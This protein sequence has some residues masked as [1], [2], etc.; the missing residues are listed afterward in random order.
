[1]KCTLEVRDSKLETP[2]FPT[3]MNRISRFSLSLV[4]LLAACKAQ[5]AAPPA[6]SAAAASAGTLTSD[7][8]TDLGLKE[9]P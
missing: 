4:V 2:P 6:E 8:L 3:P 9:L 7:L 1:M 5:N